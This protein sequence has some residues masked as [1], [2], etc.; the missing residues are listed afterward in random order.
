M[1]KGREKNCGQID[2][3]RPQSISV[4]YVR[5]CYTSLACSAVKE[6]KNRMIYES[7]NLKGKDRSEQKEKRKEYNLAVP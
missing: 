6:P 7:Q 3:N 1:R 2:L 4:A 5:H